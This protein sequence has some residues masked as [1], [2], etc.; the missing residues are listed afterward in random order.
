MPKPDTSARR[1]EKR[2]KQEMNKVFQGEP[3]I[4][5]DEPEVPEVPKSEEPE[6]MGEPTHLANL[7]AIANAPNRFEVDLKEAILMVNELVD[8]LGDR[9]A[10]SIDENGH[11]RAKRRIV[12]FVDL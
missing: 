4:S 11:V 8:R 12:Q 5:E 9:V 6:P 2:L 7:E 10:L 3:V 1:A